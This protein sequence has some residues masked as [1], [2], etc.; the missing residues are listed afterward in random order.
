[1]FRP[2]HR[3]E[4]NGVDFSNGI[5]E[6]IYASAGGTVS[7]SYVSS[8]YGEVIF[9]KHNI[10]GK[11]YETVYAHLDVDSRLVQAGQTVTQGQRIGSMGNTGDSSGIHLHFE[12]CTPN[13][14]QG[15]ANA[16]DPLPYLNGG[17]APP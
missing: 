16:I 17:T 10:K 1:P 3:P 4:H 14:V 9:I 13:W 7:Q 6:P 11:Q 8:S 12:L 15:G 2:P 5:K